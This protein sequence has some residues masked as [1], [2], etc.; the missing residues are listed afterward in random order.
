VGEV[1]FWTAAVFAVL[2]GPPLILAWGELRR[3]RREAEQL[4]RQRRSE[5]SHGERD[6][7]TN[8][9]LGSASST[10]TWPGM[11]VVACLL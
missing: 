3:E 11:F 2:G 1:L 10:G 8:G 7:P 4:R 9:A 6:G 5:E